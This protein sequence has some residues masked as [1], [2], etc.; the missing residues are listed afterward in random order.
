MCWIK[1]MKKG[2][3]REGEGMEACRVGS[4]LSSGEGGVVRCSVM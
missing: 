2:G 1:G 4:S 3:G